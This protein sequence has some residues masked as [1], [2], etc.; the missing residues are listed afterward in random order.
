VN[1]ARISRLRG[2]PIIWLAVVWL[3]VVVGVI[4]AAAQ[5]NLPQ[6]WTIFNGNWQVVD[7][8]A[9]AGGTGDEN[10]M[11]AG[12]PPVVTAGDL[13]AS[14]TIQ[15]GN[16]PERQGGFMFYASAPTRRF[17]P[18]MNGYTFDWSD[19]PG[20]RGIRLFRWDNGNP[21]GLV[22]GTPDVENPPLL[23]QVQVQGDVIRFFGDGQLILEYTDATYRSGHFGL[24]AYTPMYF[25][26]VQVGGV[27]SD[28][29]QQPPPPPPPGSESGWT[30]FNGNWEF[31]DGRVFAGG[32]GDENWMWAGSTPLVTAGDLDASVSIQ[33]EDVPERHGGFMFY[34]SAPT[35]RFFPDMNGYTFDWSEAPGE[36]GIRLFRWDNGNPVGLVVGTPNVANPPL[37][38][39]V[40]VQGDVIRFFGDGQ[41]ILEYT[42]G[43]Y[44]SGHF[45]L[46][47]Y[48][49]MYFDNVQV[50]N[51]FSDDF[52]QPPPPPPGGTPSNWTVY[53]STWQIIDGRLFT[54]DP[55]DGESWIWAGAPPLTLTG[56]FEAAVTIDFA[57][58]P[59]D[60]TGRH[61]GIMFF[62][63]VP[64]FRGDF[65]M[66]GY[67]IDWIDRPE[68][69][70]FRFIRFDNGNANVIAP[71]TPSIAEP[72][73]LWQVQVQGAM[74][75]F[76][77]D[78]QFI[79]EFTDNTYRTGH[80]GLWACCT[81]TQMYFDDVFI[82]NSFSDGF[83]QTP[84]PPPPLPPP[85]PPP[86]PPPCI[87]AAAN[88]VSWWR[89]EGDA[90]DFFGGN[91]GLL[92][93]GATFAPG[94]LG[95][96]FRF[97]GQDDFVQASTAGFPT[98]SGDRTMDLWVKV[99]DFLA[100]EA[101]FAGYG[102]FGVDS[103]IYA[104]GSSGN[105]LFFSQ[106]GGAIFGPSL[107]TN[108]WYHV[109]VT[110]E[111]NTATLYLDGSAVASGSLSINTPGGTNFYMGRLPD[112]FGA[113]RRLNGFVD[114]VGVYNRALSPSEI[115]AIFA[116]GRGGN[117]PPTTVRIDI[118]PGSAT[119]TIRLGADRTTLAAI[120]STAD[121]D[122][123]TVNPATVTLAGAPVKTRRNGSF[124]FTFRDVNRDRIQDMV[125]EFE[126][127]A[128]QLTPTDT[129][130]VLD[131][132]TF[133]GVQV[134][135]V[136]SVIVAPPPAPRLHEAHYPNFHWRRVEGAI[137]YQIQIDNDADFSSPIQDATVDG[138][139]YHADTLPNGSYY[140]RVRVGGVCTNVIVSAWSEAESFTVRR[141]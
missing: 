2:L 76:F 134:R 115:Q 30:I 118:Q 97:D 58:I 16:L 23:W 131:G 26:N 12:I 112:P 48:T 63:S 109:A 92:Q 22:V 123:R 52:Q 10:W 56:D 119:N 51:I 41:L 86:P 5:Q 116:G 7:G 137:C 33:L 136:D 60:G 14:L 84:T 75:R 39:Q 139:H 47:A 6:S 18:D 81:G 29:F 9:F 99:N 128:L 127:S 140:W 70:G 74:I 69:H 53:S 32:T 141:R 80:F 64:T 65:P 13:D 34:A 111:G 57:N 45:G 88:L 67:T 102:N 55:P 96:A 135:G 43:T 46:W 100:E 114:E 113:T 121:F 77:A 54:E 90:T 72:P 93:G 44:R 15:L 117:C 68:D 62:A 38:W 124:L 50:G 129:Q 138:T 130:A 21:V 82:G 104:V 85:P 49:P 78:G 8:R 83:G 59:Q 42:D 71:N 105:V 1:T 126:N 91:D 101:F 122:A 20:E 66:N 79:S 11:W 95:Q 25:D 37:L 3:L 98:G 61:G 103:Q 87:P 107:Q 133:A 4:P 106:W 19:A 120:L 108:R 27:F 24:W 28:D 132:Q 35:R 31:V 40:Q 36:R 125:M 89:A 94:I 73:R 17:F 110:N